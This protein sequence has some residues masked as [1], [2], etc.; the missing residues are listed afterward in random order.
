MPMFTSC[1][2]GALIHPPWTSQMCCVIPQRLLL[3]RRGSSAP[4]AACLQTQLAALLC[5]CQIYTPTK[6]TRMPSISTTRTNCWTRSSPHLAYRRE[7]LRYMFGTGDDISPHMNAD[8]RV[9]NSQGFDWSSLRC[10]S[11]AARSLTRT[12]HHRTGCYQVGC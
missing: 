2:H 8:P 6:L 12:M 7:L 10:P 5:L 9:S 1:C 4:A 11:A 3:N